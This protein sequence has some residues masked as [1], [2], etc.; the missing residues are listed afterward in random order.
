MEEKDAAARNAAVTPGKSANGS[1]RASEVHERLFRE[2]MAHQEAIVRAQEEADANAKA[3][4]NLAVAM[5]KDPSTKE[6]FL[7]LEEHAAKT[8]NMAAR[9][10][11]SLSSSAAIAAHLQLSA[12]KN[13]RDESSVYNRDDDTPG[14]EEEPPIAVRAAVVVDSSEMR[15]LPSHTQ[16]DDDRTL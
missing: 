9:S 11:L 13:I 7:E 2:G 12:S 3:L 6:R 8:G 15:V 14:P 10:S 4:S 1:R 5:V 16:S